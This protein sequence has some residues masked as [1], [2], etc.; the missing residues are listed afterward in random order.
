[1]KKLDDMRRIGAVSCLGAGIWSLVEGIETGNWWKL[2]VG[3]G[4]I[5]F[6]FALGYY[7]LR[8]SKSMSG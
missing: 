1:M 3:L 2:G 8:E 5:V 6:G 7:L 4:L